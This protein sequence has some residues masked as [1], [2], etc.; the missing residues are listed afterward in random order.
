[1]VREKEYRGIRTKRRTPTPA[2][3]TFAGENAC[4]INMRKQTQ[5]SSCLGTYQAHALSK[6]R[7]EGIEDVHGGIEPLCP[8]V[9]A[10]PDRP[11]ELLD[12][13]LEDG[14]NGAGGVAGL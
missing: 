10:A 12:L 6:S 8:L 1:M 11:L 9:I 2:K 14:K 7:R 4:Q 13:L 3:I 5:T